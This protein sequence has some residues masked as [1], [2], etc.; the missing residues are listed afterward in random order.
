[1]KELTIRFTIEEEEVKKTARFMREAKYC[2]LMRGDGKTKTFLFDDDLENGD[3]NLTE[4]EDED[5]DDDLDLILDNPELAPDLTFHEY[6][7]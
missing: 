6:I 5:I 2:I 3:N 7:G 4:V 1:M